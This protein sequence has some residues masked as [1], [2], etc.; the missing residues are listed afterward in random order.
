MFIQLGSTKNFTD[1]KAAIDRILRIW[2]GTV[3]GKD[4]A[5]CIIAGDEETY[6][7]LYHIQKQKSASHIVNFVGTR[8][9][10]TSSCTWRRIFSSGIGGLA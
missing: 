9:I 2:R 6:R 5:P 4:G 3:V 1:N 7:V 8:V 10:G